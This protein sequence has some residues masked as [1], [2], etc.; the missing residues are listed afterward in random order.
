MTQVIVYTNETGGVSVC[1]PSETAN[2]QDVLAKD[3]PVGA[4]IID[5]SELPKG[6]DDKYFDA[7]V[8]K[9]GLVIVD[10]VKKQTIIDK[11]NAEINTKNSAL[12]KLT[13]LGLTGDEVKALLGVK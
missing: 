2:I 11:Q 6:E 4:I 12:S 5:N 7:W 10:N 1:T 3:C 9:D 8:L 13:A